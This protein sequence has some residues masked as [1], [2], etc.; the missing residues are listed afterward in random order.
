VRLQF[1]ETFIFFFKHGLAP[2]VQKWVA[3]AVRLAHLHETEKFEK[4]RLRKSGAGNVC[5]D[6]SL[7]QKKNIYETKVNFSDIKIKY[8]PLNLHLNKHLN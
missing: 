2:V 8:H 6:M 5:P 1:F 3:F 7:H 4:F